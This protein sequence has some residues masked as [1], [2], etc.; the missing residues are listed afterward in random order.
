MKKNKISPF[1]E[2]WLPIRDI[3]NGMIL[4]TDKYYVTGV[5]IT[6]RNIFILD[7]DIV[8]HC[9]SSINRI[10]YKTFSITMINDKEICN[11]LIDKVN[12]IINKTDILC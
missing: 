8:Y 11:I 4:T 1:T 10:G 3:Q 6:P 9:G 2:D 7:N 12:K 5:K